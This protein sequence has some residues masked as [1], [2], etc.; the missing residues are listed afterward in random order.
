MTIVSG[1]VTV[2]GTLLESTTL[3]AKLKVPSVVGVPEITPVVVLKVRP[4]GSVPL[5]KLHT[6]GEVPGVATSVVL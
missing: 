5:A 3:T 6:N 2:N 4:G 1:A